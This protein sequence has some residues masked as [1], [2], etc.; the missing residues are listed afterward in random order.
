MRAWRREKERQKKNSDAQKARIH[1]T[2]SKAPQPN[3]AEG[4]GSV[5][6]LVYNTTAAAT[7]TAT[8]TVPEDGEMEYPARLLENVLSKYAVYAC[9]MSGATSAPAIC[10]S[11]PLSYLCL[12]P[13]ALSYFAA[14]N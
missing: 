8:T 1:F 5:I 14:A 9:A 3:I 10:A 12:Q 2:P 13:L 11:L 6:Q 7:A 4:S